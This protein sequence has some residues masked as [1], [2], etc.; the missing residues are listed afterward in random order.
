MIHANPYAAPQT[1]DS[2]LDVRKLPIATLAS[3]GALRKEFP[4]LT[5][6]QLARLVRQSRALGDM[7]LVWMWLSPLALLGVF[8]WLCVED[9]DHGTPINYVPLA[10]GIAV[11]LARLVLGHGRSHVGRYVGLLSD[12]LLVAVCVVGMTVATQNW[13]FGTFSQQM[14]LVICLALLFMPVAFGFP[15][16]VAMLE[17][18]D[19][20]GSRR[21]K[22][23]QLVEELDYRGEL[24]IE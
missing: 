5:T 12:S 3:S 2:T 4:A 23:M 20:F 17:A 14:T 21:W 13:F 19:L 6:K 7:Q 1:L 11:A 16:L 24:G 9:F 8:L 22:H 15:A 10:I 18:R